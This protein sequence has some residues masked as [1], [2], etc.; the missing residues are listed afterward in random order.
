[1]TYSWIKDLFTIPKNYILLQLYAAATNDYEKIGKQDII[2][3]AKRAVEYALRKDN[4]IVNEFLG[5]SIRVDFSGKEF[6]FSLFARAHGPIVL[7]NAIIKCQILGIEQDPYL[8]R[9]IRDVE[10]FGLSATYTIYSAAHDPIYD[11]IYFICGYYAREVNDENLNIEEIYKT[12][13]SSGKLRMNLHVEKITGGESFGIHQKVVHYCLNASTM[14]ALRKKFGVEDRMDSCSSWFVKNITMLCRNIKDPKIGMTGQ[15]ENK[16]AL[17]NFFPVQVAN[18]IRT[19][20]EGEYDDYMLHTAP[21]R[22]PLFQKNMMSLQNLVKKIYNL[23]HCVLVKPKIDEK[24]TFVPLEKLIFK[25][26]HLTAVTLPQRLSKPFIDRM[27][28]QC[29]EV[30]FSQAEGKESS[31]FIFDSRYQPKVQLAYLFV[32]KPYLEKRKIREEDSGDSYAYLYNTYGIYFHDLDRVFAEAAKQGIDL[33]INTE[34]YY[35]AHTANAE[36]FTQGNF[37][38]PVCVPIRKTEAFRRIAEQNG[39]RVV[40]ENIGNQEPA[41]GLICLYATLDSIDE[42]KK[43]LSAHP[44]VCYFQAKASVTQLTGIGAKTGFGPGK[45]THS[46]ICMVFDAYYKNEIEYIF[47]KTKFP[48]YFAYTLEDIRKLGEQDVL[49]GKAKGIGTS[50]FAAVSSD[51]ERIFKT[52]QHYSIPVC[53]NSDSVFYQVLDTK[54]GINDLLYTLTFPAVYRSEINSMIEQL[55]DIDSADRL[56]SREDI[57]KY[58]WN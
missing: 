2:E 8:S 17:E 24:S 40:E 30:L 43:W 15:M 42:L 5:V 58:I 53:I 9:L 38:Y 45:N 57:N 35:F 19:G 28:K 23:N 50:S 48:Q 3:Y 37:V 20:G 6:D 22:I 14:K 12:Q 1:M 49:N 25:T 18:E 27:I 52:V 21:E 39:I 10:R 31:T 34:K 11:G 55:A 29:S 51:L 13:Y 36:E 33:C 7:Q 26:G 54:T 32:S 41:H 47:L 56:L 16:L 4:G 46:S 44:E